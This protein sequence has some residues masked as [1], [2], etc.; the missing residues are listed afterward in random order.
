MRFLGAV[1]RV[2]EVAKVSKKQGCRAFLKMR[3]ALRRRSTSPD[4]CMNTDHSFALRLNGGHW[5]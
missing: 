2:G 1:Q 4:D 3:F 5:F